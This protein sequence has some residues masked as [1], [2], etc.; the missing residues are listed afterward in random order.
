MDNYKNKK[1]LK[2]K[3]EGKNTEFQNERKKSF[4]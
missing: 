1:K 3:N 2:K 4:Q